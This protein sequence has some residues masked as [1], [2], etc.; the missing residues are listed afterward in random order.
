[1]IF[2]HRSSIRVFFISG[3]RNPFDVQMRAIHFLGQEQ[4]RSSK[5]LNEQSND[6]MQIKASEKSKDCNND[7]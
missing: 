7:K 1:M 6:S 3:Q 4:Y 5:N 2:I